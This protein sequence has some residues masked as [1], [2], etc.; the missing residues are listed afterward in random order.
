MS[1]RL[2]RAG[3]DLDRRSSSPPRPGAPPPPFAASSPLITD[4]GCCE[5]YRP[6]LRAYGLWFTSSQLPTVRTPPRFHLLN[7]V[8]IIPTAYHGMEEEAFFAYTLH[9]YTRKHTHEKTGMYIHFFFQF[10][11]HPKAIFFL[12]TLTK[13]PY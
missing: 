12:T 4:L 8:L 11:F 6:P 7:L 13:A 1:C 3:L 10:C 2:K 5:L 9:M